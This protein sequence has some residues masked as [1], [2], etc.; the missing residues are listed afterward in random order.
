MKFEKS[1]QFIKNIKHFGINL[2][3]DVHDLQIENKIAMKEIK[4]ELNKWKHILPS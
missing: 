1:Q 2:T 4:E 3:K